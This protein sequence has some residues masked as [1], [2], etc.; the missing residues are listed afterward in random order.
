MVYHTLQ[1]CDY[2]GFE[3]AGLRHQLPVPLLKIESD[4]TTQSRGAAAHPGWKPSPRAS[5]P[6]KETPP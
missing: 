5:A 4:G 6:R 3:Y 2:Y 1:F